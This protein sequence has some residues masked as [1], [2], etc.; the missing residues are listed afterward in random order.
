MAVAAICPP[1]LGC[2]VREGPHRLRTDDLNAHN[3]LDLAVAKAV[4]KDVAKDVDK[5]GAE[6]VLLAE[7]DRHGR[8]EPWLA[9]RLI[10]R[11][12][13]YINHWGPD[14]LTTQQHSVQLQGDRDLQRRLA[15][16]Q[17]PEGNRGLL[18]ATLAASWI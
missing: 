1:V 12:R 18:K 17:S 13:K 2:P 7:L 9:S 6:M 11:L 4:A 14:C 8:A 10:R 3:I 16:S 15:A 5:A